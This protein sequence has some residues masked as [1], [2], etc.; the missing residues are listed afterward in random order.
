[1]PGN[2]I[3][4]E[5]F[6]DYHEQPYQMGCIKCSNNIFHIE[7]IED[8]PR[9]KLGYLRIKCAVCGELVGHCTTDNVTWGDVGRR[10]EDDG[11]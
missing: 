7:K 9:G 2:E 10:P 5:G 8:Q 11:E 3:A 4:P 1:M 6:W